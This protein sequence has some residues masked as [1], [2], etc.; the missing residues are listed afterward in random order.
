VHE[1]EGRGKKLK[2]KRVKQSTRHKIGVLNAEKIATKKKT[3][4]KRMS[5]RW[6]KYI[7]NF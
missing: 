5:K 4:W 6:G 2:K 1:V 7:G 3:T